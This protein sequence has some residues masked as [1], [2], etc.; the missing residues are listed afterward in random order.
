MEITA[1]AEQDCTVVAVSGRLD[2]GTAADFDKQAAAWPGQG[3]KRLVLD[4]GQLDYISSAG[5]R[6]I[7]ALGKKARAAGGSLCLCCPR[8]VVAEVISLSGFDSFLAVHPSL[9]TALQG[10]A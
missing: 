5:L 7:L 8:G 2:T 1:R 6:S 4:L 3:P 10:G 9:E